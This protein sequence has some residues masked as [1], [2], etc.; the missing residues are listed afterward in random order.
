MVE[1]LTLNSYNIRSFF[2]GIIMT[3]ERY[4][5]WEF[6][7]DKDTGKNPRVIAKCICGNIKSVFYHSVT[8][9]KSKSCGCKAKELLSEAFT[10]H[11]MY[12][13]PIYICWGN[14]I[15]R[16]NN[17]KNN[18]YHRYGARGIKICDRW[19]DF[20]SFYDDMGDMPEGMSIDR[21]DNEGDYTLDNCKWSSRSEQALNTRVRKDNKTGLKGVFFNSQRKR[22][23]AYDGKG[24]TLYYG[25]LFFD[26]CCARK[27]YENRLV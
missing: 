20:Q 23:L 1:T 14:I 25:S 22:W 2:E 27:S 19:M 24:K 3:G 8:S 6:V 17:P 4:G 11:G 7:G 9:G 26:A 12:G 13:T 5:F 10:T 18:N 21:I 15:Q 16:C